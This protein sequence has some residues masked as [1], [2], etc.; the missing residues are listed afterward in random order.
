M[1]P[2]KLELDKQF[3]ILSERFVCPNMK[4]TVVED[5]LECLESGEGEVNLDEHTMEKASESLVRMLE[6]K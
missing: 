2:L 1:H 6:I 5:V 3:H 4:R